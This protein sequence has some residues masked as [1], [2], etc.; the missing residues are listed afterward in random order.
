MSRAEHAT[1]DRR[2]GDR[3]AAGDPVPNKPPAPQPV[4][5]KPPP[6]APPVPDGVPPPVRDPRRPEHPDPVR[7]PPTERPPLSVH[8]QA[9]R[10][11]RGEAAAARC[12]P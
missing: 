11:V 9:P 6:S 4:P 3:R 1:T 10:A 12:C 5:N 8:A 7:E 2:A